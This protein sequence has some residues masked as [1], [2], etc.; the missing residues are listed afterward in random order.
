MLRAFH[1]CLDTIEISVIF[2]ATWICPQCRAALRLEKAMNT[3]KM[4]SNLEDGE[5]SDD[6]APLPIFNESETD[7]NQNAKKLNELIESI[8]SMD[9]IE[10][11]LIEDEPGEPSD[12]SGVG[13]SDDMKTM[14]LA[15]DMKDG[16]DI[17][18]KV[19]RNLEM[20][21]KM[22]VR[23]SVKVVPD[24][25]GEETRTRPIANFAEFPKKKPVEHALPNAYRMYRVAAK[26]SP[27]RERVRRIEKQQ[28]LYILIDSG[29]MDGERI[30][31]AGGVLMNRLKAVI[32]GDAQVYAR[33]FDDR[34]HRE[35]FAG[36]PDEAKALMKKFEEENFSG[37]GTDIVGSMKGAQ[38]RIEKILKESQ[39]L[40][41]PELVVITDGDDRNTDEL[42]HKG[43]AP[44]TVH[45]FIID[46]NK[47]D[48]IKFARD[49]G[50]VGVRVSTEDAKG[51]I[52][53]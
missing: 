25:E 5:P 20:S 33:F 22:Q 18:L 37:G 49:T 52:P 43:F 23:K 48:L 24:V 46:T 36:T 34:L 30:K 32:S 28:L 4:L 40:T 29:S 12:S 15:H 11:S 53:F 50:G 13:N 16:K 26:V 8:E 42:Q 39:S 35:Y 45:A 38:E 31:Q 10:K 7:S 1:F 9:E 17:W 27:I 51:E 19:S 14:S 21:A 6:G 47:T 41:R 3:L 44:T 2:Y